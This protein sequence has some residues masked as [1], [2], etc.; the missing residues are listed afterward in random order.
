LE[1]IEKQLE[2]VISKLNRLGESKTS[3]LG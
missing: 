3:R 2:A 1:R